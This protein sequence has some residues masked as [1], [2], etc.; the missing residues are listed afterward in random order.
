M[1]ELN[2]AKKLI[3]KINDMSNEEDLQTMRDSISVSDASGEAKALILRA[4]DIKL[5]PNYNKSALVV[6]GDFCEGDCDFS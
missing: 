2:R 1:S 5:D 4:L 6:D 3:Y